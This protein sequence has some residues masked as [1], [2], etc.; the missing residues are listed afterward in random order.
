MV[1]AVD[2]TKR[3]YYKDIALPAKVDP[4]SAKVDPDSA[5]ATY[6]NGILEITFEKA[7]SP[8]GRCIKVD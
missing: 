8:S 4:D 6:K 7:G 5:K 2:S 1:I 3:R